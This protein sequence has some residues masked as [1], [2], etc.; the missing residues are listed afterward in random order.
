MEYSALLLLPLVGGFI[1]T[2][3]WEFTRYN[4]ARSDGQRLYF[5]SAFWGVYIGLISYTLSFFVLPWFALHLPFFN[6]ETGSY[7]VIGAMVMSP[8]VGYLCAKILNHFCDEGYHLE[9]ALELDQ[10]ELLLV[11]AVLN[12]WLVMLSLDDSAGGK[13]YVGL[14][15]SISDPA[16]S[17][18]KNIGLI[19]VLSGYRTESNK[20]EFTTSYADVLT[21][22]E[23]DSD[24]LGHLDMDDFLV[25]LPMSRIVSARLFDRNAYD[26]FQGNES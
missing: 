16:M 4:L 21:G 15:P 2:K 23:G 9:R 14:V 25:V 22:V 5:Y 18:R 1:F 17:K 11:D 10:L 13:V 3:E 12:G 26:V 7:V 24:D 8:T 20:V 19:P 6:I